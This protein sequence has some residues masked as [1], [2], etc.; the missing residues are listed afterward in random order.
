M[1]NLNKVG[2]IEAIALLVTVITNNIIFNVPSIILNFVGSGAWLSIIYLLVIT[3]IY[4]IVICKLLN[5]FI[6]SDIIDV[7]EFLGGKTLKFIVGILYIFLFSTFAGGC[8][9]YLCN[10]LH[11]IYF[12]DTPLLFLLLLFIIPVIIANK[13][14]VKAIAG[15]NLIFLPLALI[16][17]IILFFASSKDF[18]WQ[19]LFPIFGYSAKNLFINQIPNISAFNVVGYLYFAKP[20][21]KKDE[22]FKGIS[23]LCVIIS[24]IYLLISII[25]LLMTF[26]FITQTDQTLSLYLLTR[27]V[28]FGNFFQRADAIFIFLWILEVL[29]FFSFNTLLIITILKKMFNLKYS[30][31]LCYSLSAILLG[32][33]L[34]FPDIATVKSFNRNFYRVFSFV[35]VFIFSFLIFLLAYIKRKRKGAINE[36][37]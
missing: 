26:P 17:I 11:L 9:R 13:Y 15:T 14:G 6:D 1:D 37:K 27:L 4:I 20:F 19:R 8:I 22:H 2:K 35:I 24:G 7:S 31:E 28:S 30:S 34:S 23:I 25:S 29:S 16:S 12:N 18:V 33:S 36:S 32:I 5:P 10:S 21:L 3:L